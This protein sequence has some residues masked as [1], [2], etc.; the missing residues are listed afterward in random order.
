MIDDVLQPAVVQWLTAGAGSPALP[1]IRAN[2]A[3]LELVP[4][5]CITFQLIGADPSGHEDYTKNGT[6]IEGDIEISHYQKTKIMVSVNV[7]SADGAA[8][9]GRIW[10]S[11]FTYSG[12]YP[13]NQVRAS[14][15]DF[16]GVRDLTYKTDTGFQ[17][18]FQSDFTLDYRTLLVE[19]N[20][21][22][23]YLSVQGTIENESV[24]IIGFD[25]LPEEV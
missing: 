3:G 23:D 11:R 15:V 17:P 14:L 2:Q 10:Q 16:S 21:Q 5:G 24:T 22:V 9:L 20:K 13:L 25:N 4:G 18:R 19:A 6:L 12:R 1:V 8:R 7:Y